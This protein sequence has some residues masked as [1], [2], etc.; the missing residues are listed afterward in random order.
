MPRALLHH[1]HPRQARSFFRHSCHF[2]QDTVKVIIKK[3]QEY[4]W[5]IADGLEVYLGYLKFTRSRKISSPSPAHSW[6]I[7]GIAMD[8]TTTTPEEFWYVPT[9]S[10]LVTMLMG[11]HGGLVAVVGFQDQIDQLKLK[12]EPIRKYIWYHMIIWLLQQDQ[13]TLCCRRFGN[14]LSMPKVQQ[15]FIF[16]ICLVVNLALRC[17]VWS[18]CGCG[19]KS[20]K[21]GLGGEW[22]VQFWWCLQVC[23]LISFWLCFVDSLPSLGCTSCPFGGTWSGMFRSSVEQRGWLSSAFLWWSR[24]RLSPICRG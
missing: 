24:Q 7:Y 21:Y 12:Q 22:G 2:L 19:W 8:T 11:C 17:L 13:M 4:F 3:Y 23:V 16:S 14:K 1:L 6:N 9:V 10:V 15:I 20:W 5:R 18:A